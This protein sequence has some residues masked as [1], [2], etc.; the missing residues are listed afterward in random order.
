MV[1]A[2]SLRTMAAPRQKEM[3]ESATVVATTTLAAVAGLVDGSDINVWQQQLFYD[4]SMAETNAA[5]VARRIAGRL[6]SSGYQAFLVGGCVRDLLLGLEPKDFDIATDARP[7]AV[8]QL[9]PGAISVGA[10]FG[11]VLVQ[12][13]D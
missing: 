12:D 4:L 1:E 8:L 13:G 9:F 11:V 10:H 5:S 3:K 7:E 6:R 2:R